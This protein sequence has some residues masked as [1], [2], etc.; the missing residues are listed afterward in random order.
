MQEPCDTGELGVGGHALAGVAIRVDGHFDDLHSVLEMVGDQVSLDGEESARGDRAF[1]LARGEEG[2]QE[3]DFTRID[4]DCMGLP[5]W[6]VNSALI[7]DWVVDRSI[8]SPIEAGVDRVPPI[9][10]TPFRPQPRCQPGPLKRPRP[11][12]PTCQSDGCAAQ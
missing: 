9:P 4:G 1:F 11:G 8:S 10:T 12:G 7:S 6:S 5:S 2:N 3:D